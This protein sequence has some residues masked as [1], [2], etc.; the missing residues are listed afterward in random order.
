MTADV[1]FHGNQKE[2]FEIVEAIQ[3]NCGCDFG[4]GN[5]RT[6]TCAPH[7]ALIHDQR[8][9]NGLLFVRTLRLQLQAEEGKP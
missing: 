2:A 6:S 1:I 4:P 5:V 7:D 3:H 9:V 8:Y